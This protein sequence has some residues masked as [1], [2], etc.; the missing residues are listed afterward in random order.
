MN[1]FGQLAFREDY[2]RGLAYL[3]GKLSKKHQADAV[4]CVL[5]EVVTSVNWILDQPGYDTSALKD[6]EIDA[7]LLFRRCL[8][9]GKCRT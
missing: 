5:E 3:R 2:R 7:L 1:D 6:Y 9:E 4:R 8:R